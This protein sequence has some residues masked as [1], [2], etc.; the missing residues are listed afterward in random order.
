MTS[1]VFR[2]S[3]ATGM[4]RAGLTARDIADQL[5]HTRVSMTQDAYLGRRI[6]NEDAA[7]ALDDA[8]RASREDDP[9]NDGGGAPVGVSVH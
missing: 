4:E 2:K 1:H 5:G 9:S 7:A 8:Y 3:A 6:L